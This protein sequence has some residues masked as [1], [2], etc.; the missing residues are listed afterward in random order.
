MKLLS[1]HF[2]IVAAS[3]ACT[4]S[5]AQSVEV[6]DAWIRGTVPAQKATGAFMDITAKNNARLISV[7]SKIAAS[8]E[9]HNMTMNNGVM[10][11]FPVDGVDVPAGKT[12]KL[13][14]GGYHVM[15]IGLK[16]QMKPGDRVPLKL[17]FELADKKRES[18]EL[19][20]EVRDIKGERRDMQH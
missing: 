15:F 7:E 13:A 11:M 9:I 1:P 14:P 6:K 5:H 20:V 17:N 8:T 2:V 19:S 10:K 4:L 16:E 12:V 18:V 3:L